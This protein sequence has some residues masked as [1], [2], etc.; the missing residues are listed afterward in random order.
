[1]KTP[2]MII[3]GF[4]GAG[5]TT[6]IQQFINEY[7]APERLMILENDFGRVSYDAD[8]L[9]NTGIQLTQLTSGCICCSLAGDF[10]TSVLQALQAT[11]QPIDLLIIEPSGVAKLSDI[12][13]A[14]SS[15]EL[16]EKVSVDYIITIAD[17]QQGTLL[18]R[19]F[20]EF[21]KNQL[22]YAHHIFLSQAHVLPAQTKEL[23]DGIQDIN[24]VAPIH[25]ESWQDISL[26]DYLMSPASH[27]NASITEK[28]SSSHTETHNHGPH[29]ADND[30]THNHNC[31]CHD[32]HHDHNCG[33]HDEHHDHHEHS[34]EHT[35]HDV[36]AAIT[37]TIQH[38]HAT[39]SFIAAIEQLI[40]AWPHHILRIKGI[41]PTPEGY[42]SFQYNGHAISDAPIDIA[43]NSLTIIGSHLSEDEVHAVWDDAL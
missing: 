20:G 4:L 18:L 15:K 14:C 22:T 40:H 43:G 19:N 16:E 37:L 27:D 30:G 25:T 39:S 21:Y 42:R 10:K 1:M 26:Y 36:F 23:I 38:P 31:G 2:I 34:H 41:L 33:C 8:I 32:E 9:S 17:A 7:P 12:I 5:K 24:H 3:S 28:T 13:Q 6:F 29:Q 35:A 11:D